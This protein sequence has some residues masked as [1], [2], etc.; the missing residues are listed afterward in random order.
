MFPSNLRLHPGSL[1][2]KQEDTY[3]IYKTD[4][5]KIHVWMLNLLWRKHH[6]YIYNFQFG[7]LPCFGIDLQAKGCNS[8]RGERSSNNAR[9][10]KVTIWK[11]LRRIPNFPFAHHTEDKSYRKH[12][13]GKWRG[14]GNH[15]S[16]F[17]LPPT[18]PNI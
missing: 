3:Y 13:N 16:Y 11:W 15:Q 4:Q 7:F 6:L 10:H 14:E 9:T 12:Y 18:K 1:L 17:Q 8:K 2:Y 5:S